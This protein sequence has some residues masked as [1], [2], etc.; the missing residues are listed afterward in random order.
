[1]RALWALTGF[2]GL[3]RRGAAGIWWLAY[4]TFF[5]SIGLTANFLVVCL[6]F[7]C[8]QQTQRKY[9]RRLRRIGA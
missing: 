2:G 5:W 1:M 7:G 8:S 3:G 6:G 9:E 4:T